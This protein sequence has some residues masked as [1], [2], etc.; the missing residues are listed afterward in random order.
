[1][2]KLSQKFYDHLTE[3]FLA[4]KFVPCGKKGWHFDFSD[5]SVHFEV[6]ADLYWGEIN[7]HYPKSSTSNP[8]VTIEIDELREFCEKLLTIPLAAALRD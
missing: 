3:A 5:R 1:M 4:G 6:R 8:D 7:K 2:N